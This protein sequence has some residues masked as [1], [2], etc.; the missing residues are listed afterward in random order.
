MY[1]FTK[2]TKR[3]LRNYKRWNEYMIVIST[4]PLNFS[5]KHSFIHN[6]Q[7]ADIFID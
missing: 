7:H 5:Y 2:P 1:L 6:I 4:F 3:T